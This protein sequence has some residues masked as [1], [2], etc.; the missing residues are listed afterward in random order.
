MNILNPYS[1]V[2]LDGDAIMRGVTLEL[3]SER[4]RMLLPHGL[5]LGEQTV[6][7][8]GTHPVI[9]L[10]NEMLRVHMSVPSLLPSMS[11][12]ELS[13][14]IPNCYIG[15]LGPFYFQPRLFLDSFLA[16][17]GGVF[18]WGF[19]KRMASF[20][21][22]EE[23]FAVRGVRG[24]ALTSL[25]HRP[26]GEELPVAAYPNFAPIRA[27]HDQP[28]VLMLPAG[29][30]PFFVCSNFDKLW[31]RGTLQPLETTTNVEESY[32]P[33]LATGSFAAH[34]VD[35][36]VLGSYVMRMPWRLSMPYSPYA[37]GMI[38]LSV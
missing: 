14:G 28:L 34:G 30:G 18:Y 11:Y 24:N 1:Y 12:R 17:L 32:L 5:E 4:L 35:A 15:K 25:R 20:T 38:Q 31:E 23:E 19:P 10:F 22:N 37:A 27:M 16:T 6:T 36:S 21:I 13:F 2:S 3:P 33:G 8:P 7:R 9:L 29:M 26:A